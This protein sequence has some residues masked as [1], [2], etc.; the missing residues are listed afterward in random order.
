MSVAPRLCALYGTDEPPPDRVT[1][2]AGPLE[3]TFEDGA[4]RTVAV[5]GHEV[6]RA[7]AFLM[8]GPAPAG[9]SRTRGSK[10]S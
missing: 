4:L 7:V 3:A 8:R 2:R 1:L 10:S 9:S 5:G 6:P